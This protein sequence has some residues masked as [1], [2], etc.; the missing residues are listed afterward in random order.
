MQSHELRSTILAAMTTALGLT[1]SACGGEKPAK[2]PD[3]F[4]TE[5][6]PSGSGS[7]DHAA[8]PA[9]SGSAMEM[10]CSADMM[11]KKGDKKPPP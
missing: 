6:P 11:D 8:M 2:A 4:A 9:P 10:S 5:V 7:T 3:L 1:V